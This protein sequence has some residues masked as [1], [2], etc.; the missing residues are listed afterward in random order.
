MHL[1]AEKRATEEKKDKKQYIKERTKLP[2]E[3]GKGKE[4]KGKER[5]R[6]REKEEEIGDNRVVWERRHRYRQW[7]RAIWDRQEAN[8]GRERGGVLG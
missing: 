2:L 6:K 8:Y 4:G 3:R 7:G 5:E 1:K